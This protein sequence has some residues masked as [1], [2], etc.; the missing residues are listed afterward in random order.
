MR[1]RH[2]APPSVFGDVLR[3]GLPAALFS[4]L[5]STAY[6]VLHGRDPLEATVAAGSI[7]L[8]VERRRGRLLM[9]AIPVHLTLS[10]VWTAAIAVVLPC[11]RP[12]AE[13]TLAGLAIAALDLGV[14]GRRFPRI[15]ALQTGLQIAD[16]MAF[17]IIAAAV[18]ARQRNRFAET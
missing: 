2:S 18:L 6:A 15:K 7:L 9:A 17:G 8:P 12:L 16:H 4:G 14:I 5:P 13:G 3:A 1:T 10:A 11:R